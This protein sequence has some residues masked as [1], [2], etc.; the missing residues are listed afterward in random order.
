MEYLVQAVRFPKGCL[1]GGAEHGEGGNTEI[2]PH[3]PHQLPGRVHGCR[4]GQHQQ[5]RILDG[6]GVFADGQKLD[7]VTLGLE[8]I[9]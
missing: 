9:T 4:A 6:P 3:D 8:A 5:D 2:G 1:F 7:G